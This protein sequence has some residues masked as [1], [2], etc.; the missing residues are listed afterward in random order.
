MTLCRLA[1]EEMLPATANPLKK[2]KKLVLVEA[3][4]RLR[5][6]VSRPGPKSVGVVEDLE[7]RSDEVDVRLEQDPR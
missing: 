7:V 4:D 3:R 5:G 6:S 1:R 2:R